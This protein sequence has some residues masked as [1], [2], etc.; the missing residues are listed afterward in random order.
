M[1]RY[2]LIMRQVALPGLPPDWPIPL[3]LQLGLNEVLLLEGVGWNDARSF[4]QVAATLA[5]PLGGEVLY[6]GQT[7]DNLTRPGLFHLRKQIAFIS[8]GQV[9]LQHLNLGEN[10]TL[11]LCYHRDLTISQ[12]LEEHGELLD[13]F[14]LRPFLK[15]LPAQLP[16]YIY[17][18]SIWARELIKE[19]EL[20]LACL[21]GPGWMRRN[22]EILHEV[23]AACLASSRAAFLLAGQDLSSFYPGA[24][25]LLRPVAG[26]F[27]ETQLLQNREKSP[28]MFFPLV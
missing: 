24:H 26:S 4:W 18:R 11:S 6:W 10:I 22:Q 12:A 23:L 15:W 1:L 28:V 27:L 20:V 19:P 16:P 5:A 14:E 7:R 3:D 13:K 2:S 9:L 21:E 25:R 17:W 8:A